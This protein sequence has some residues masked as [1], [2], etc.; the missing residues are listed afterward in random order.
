M[1]K[2][3]NNKLL[4]FGKLPPQ[5]VDLE[6]AVL[7]SVLLES[8]A[9]GLIAEYF[10]PEVFYKDAH[11]KIAQ[12]IIELSLK[13]EPIDIL[14]VTQSLKK[15]GNLDIAGGPFYITQLTNK[16]ASSANIDYHMKMLMQYHIKRNAIAIGNNIIQSAY[17]DASDI[18]DMIDQ[19]EKS[20]NELTGKVIVGKINRVSTLYKKFLEQNDKIV[21]SKNGINGV[22]SGFIDIDNVTG[23]WQK[24]DLIILA[25]RPGMGK[26][27]LALSFLINACSKHKRKGAFFSLEMTEMQLLARMMAQMTGNNSQKYFRYG[28]K[29]TEL[30]S[31]ELS[32]ASLLNSDC[33]IDDTAG[34][35]IFELRNKARKLKRDHDIEF[36][37]VDYLQLMTSGLKTFNKEDEVSKISAGLKKIAKELEIPVIAL[38]QLSRSVETRGGDKEP[39]LS[40]LRDS[41]A[42]EQDADI[43]LFVHRAEYY[44]ITQDK[45][46]NSLEGKAL[47]KIA[48]HR[49]GSTSDEYLNFESKTTRFY[50]DNSALVNVSEYNKIIPNNAFFEDEF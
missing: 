22:E 34:I 3:H 47:I 35:S 12:A 37:I 40:D 11:Q 23:G 5:A 26:T 30:K 32:I 38:S 50:D 7:G 19:A 18:F 42:I 31:N 39:I 44:G 25:G 33:F 45:L 36:I 28:L 48:K 4:E 24:S 14:S 29:E 16:V 49:N 2:K 20:V 9:I 13:S 21:L 43:V 8:N 27:S 10:K 6:E 1:E 41:G 15:S 46:G 17:D